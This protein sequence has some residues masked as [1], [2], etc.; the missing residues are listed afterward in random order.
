M[1]PITELPKIWNSIK[2]DFKAPEDAVLIEMISEDIEPYILELNEAMGA[3]DPET[4]IDL[5]EKRIKNRMRQ[6]LDTST[7]DHNQSSYK[8]GFTS[9]SEKRVDAIFSRFRL[10]LK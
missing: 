5:L 6:E 9:D 3:I 1:T 4:A 8:K 7:G 2:T 10:L